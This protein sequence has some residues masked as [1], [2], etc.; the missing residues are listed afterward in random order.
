MPRAFVKPPPLSHGPLA[1][2]VTRPQ[3]QP[4]WRVPPREICACA[5]LDGQLPGPLASLTPCTTAYASCHTLASIGAP[6]AWRWGRCTKV[7]PTPKL[8]IC[9]L[10]FL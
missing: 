3:I 6:L 10:M 1:I 5:H 7:H 9:D 8:Y 2:G 4:G